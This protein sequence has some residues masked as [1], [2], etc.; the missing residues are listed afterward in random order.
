MDRKLIDMSLFVADTIN[1]TEQI[2]KIDS[3]FTAMLTPN[4]IFCTTFIR[5]IVASFGLNHRKSII[6]NS[7]VFQTKHVDANIL[8]T[9][10]LYTLGM[11]FLFIP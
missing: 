1:I 4:I 8:L 9:F 11:L 5:T 2:L 7:S 3:I 6:A 10:K